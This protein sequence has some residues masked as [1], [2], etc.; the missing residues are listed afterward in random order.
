MT[1]LEE[2]R[3]VA[4]R[5][6]AWRLLLSL[7]LCA[8]IAVGLAALGTVRGWALRGEA[9]PLAEG[10][11]WPSDIRG[12]S[13]QACLACHGDPGLTMTFPSGEVL[14]L[15]M[16][17]EAFRGSVHGDRLDCV[18]CHSRNTG[19]PHLPMEVYSRR[20]FARAEYELC[21]RCHFENYSRTLD[22]IHF[23][24][25]AQGNVNAPICTDCHTAHTVTMEKSRAAIA[26][27]CSQCHGEIYRAYS[28]S[29]HGSALRAEN[30][31]V[32]VCITCHGVHNIGSA[33]S[34]TFRQ[35]SVDLC[36]KCH[37]D[38]ELMGKYGISSS[39]LKTYL[40]DFHGKTVGFYQEQTS[41]V[42]PDV[43]VCSDCHGVHDIK[44]VDDPESRVIKENLLT[45]CRRCHPDATA[46]FPSAWLSHY[47][48]SPD[49]APLVFFVKRYYQLL[50]PLMVGGLALNILLDLWRLARNR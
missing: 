5:L 13:N 17:A 50:I 37:A 25:M 40:D 32:P 19:Y 31:D 41:D 47:E 46:N 26:Q 42:W 29:V 38:K 43:A 36:A 18:D 34:P 9:G 44:P 8:A 4:P 6:R 49:K 22:S 39:V 24:A 12:N 35:A 45:T 48:P 23:D 3:A 10:S 7:A 28:E 30:P 33:T 16:D 2:P 1:R 20:D 15:Y 21:K 27:T 14:S 11:A